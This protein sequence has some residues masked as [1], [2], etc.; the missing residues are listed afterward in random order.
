MSVSWQNLRPLNNSQNTAFEELCCQLASA[1]QVP[2][3]SKFIR[4]GTPDAGVECY[5]KLPSGD[6]WAWQA[7]F[8][9]S[10]PENN[11]WAQIDE[12]LKTAL[13]K[14]PRLTSYTV[15]LPIDRSDPRHQEQIWF[16]DRWNS[17]VEKWRIWAEDK[18]MAVEFNY[19]GESELLLRLSREEHRGRYYFWFNRER[20]S[21]LWFEQHV[22]T[23]IQNAGP[24]Y[25]PELNVDLPIAKIFDGLGRTKAFFDRLQEL[26]GKIKRAHSKSVSVDA[27]AVAQAKY[28]A[29][30]DNV[31]QLLQI[32]SEVDA[33]NIEPLNF[34]LIAEL[35]SQLRNR[36]WETSEAL[37]E[38][39]REVVQVDSDEKQPERQ[40]DVRRDFGYR[41]H[42]LQ[43]L[44]NHAAEL[45]D[46]ARSKEGSLANTPALLLKGNA[47][48]GKSHLL[49]DV[50]R[51]RVK[52]GIPT[53]L[54][55]G[56]QFND[57]E[58]WSQILSILGLTCSREELLGALE[59]A[60]QAR[61]S[62]ALIIIDA[63]N[64]GEGKRL[65][66]KYIA[67][68]LT[69]VLHYP[70]LG[71]ALSVRSSYKN[72]VIPEG[73]IPERL[74]SAEHSGFSEHEY[75]ATSAFFIHYG[76]KAPSVPLL[77]P[78]F[79]NPLFLK[80]FC[81]GLVN[82]GLTEVPPGL[83]GIT[84]I[85][86]FFI[87]SVNKRLSDAELLD[88]DERSKLI[89]KVVDAITLQM[90]QA[91][92][93]W[94]N[95]EEAQKLVNSY[96]PREGYE[97]SLFRH[98][99][100]EGLLAEDMFL[101]EGEGWRLEEGV[102]FSYERL[103]DHLVVK[104]ILENYLNPEKPEEAFASEA[105]LG[106][107]LKDESEVWQN[108]GLIEAL[109]IQLPERIGRELPE[110]VPA[111]ADT[112]PVL[113]AFIESIKWRKQGAINDATYDYINNHVLR[114]RH[115][116]YMIW[117]TLLAVASNKEH[118]LNADYLHGHLMRFEMAERDAWWSVFLH[119]QYRY[120][121]GNSINRLINW[122]WSPNDKSHIDDE[123]IWLSATALSWLLT[124]SNRY[125]R[126]RATKALVSLL[127]PRINVLRIL[128]DRFLDVND[129]YVLERIFSVAYGCAMRSDDHDSVALLASDVYQW[130]FE[131]GEP[132]L[133]ITL[134]DYARGVIE[135]AIH[136]GS[137]LDI[138]VTKIRPPYKSDWPTDIPSKEDVESNKE[139]RDTSIY[140]SV[141][142]WGDFSRYVIGTNTPMFEWTSRRLGEPP[143]PKEQYDAFVASLTKTQLK[144]F[145]LLIRVRNNI[146]YYRKLDGA[147][148]KEIWGF[149]VS[150]EQLDLIANSYEERTRKTLGKKKGEIFD[151]VVVAYLKKPDKSEDK[152]EFDLSI[153]QRWILKQVFDLGW[154]KERFDKF[155]SEVTQYEYHGRS[156]RKPER[157]GKKY[158]W[159]A[160]HEVLAR[161]SDNFIYKGDRWD[162]HLE[163]YQGPWQVFTRDID[164]SCLIKSTASGIWNNHNHTWWFPVI[165][166]H[167]EEIIDAKEWIERTDDLP[168]VQPLINVVNPAD[169]SEW[170]SL[171]AR[172]EWKPPVPIG[173]E[174]EGN[175]SRTLWYILRSSLVRKEDMEEI[176]DWAQQ[177]YCVGNF[178][179]ES[180]SIYRVFLGEFHWGP[181]YLFH[182][183]PYYNHPGWSRV[184][185]ENMT[186]EFH[187]TTETYLKE[188]PKYDCSIDDGYKIEVP[189]KL[190]AD[191]M[192]LNWRSI[193]GNYY[194]QRGALIAFDPSVRHDGPH[195]LLIRKKEFLNFL[196]VNGYDILWTV[197]GEKYQYT[198]SP[199]SEGWYGRLEI[200]GAYRMMAGQLAGALR[201]R[202]D[203]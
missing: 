107:L 4:K 174:R 1:E 197:Y 87:A 61:G 8:F 154:T 194:D 191:G 164:P 58:P 162:G 30:N 124:T 71:I 44:A 93:T 142:G 170:L 9:L 182:N 2:Q 7:K 117:D 172:Y 40:K 151:C 135:K 27:E 173:E 193:E 17:Q 13:E 120:G 159:I 89:Q 10:R 109:C 60:A 14:H 150:D 52:A 36:A 181:A 169:G 16:M 83:Q 59:S 15:C 103:S 37:E 96:L 25:T 130:I 77:N 39:K 12:S 54:I 192:D 99:L 108:R 152:H 20:F 62:K 33:Q 94:L 101:S 31:A 78:E 148:R 156:E 116:N 35:A 177:R 28:A 74:I 19:W 111:V 68:M 18:G 136:N 29:L 11:Q 125:L 50:A 72:T 123:S 73:L 98:M 179:P 132:P 45:S 24:R 64:E 22:E 57:D 82:R 186:S 21:Q 5:W 184:N 196:K 79:Q 158:Q 69:Q 134:R 178:M 92:K 190:I 166:N 97:N 34:D 113:E 188:S 129:P 84:A 3:G 163:L 6:E 26:R 176:Y 46:F 51:E 160:Y 75:E 81:K 67:G 128:I 161:V 122:A 114:F 118:P 195:A 127:T 200:D 155:D 119:K 106:S 189:T 85:F 126:D 187:A 199:G 175:L 141:M 56:E 115:F 47:G 171:D 201:S 131:D 63:L 147:E 165:Y 70:W 102:R 23:S 105:T 112:N 143:T 104:Y 121:E 66:R 146:D 145:E 49:C 80:L 140:H 183:V 38:A 180:Q 139:W 86:D 138:D 76:I 41:R 48:T 185:D 32:L 167:W 100:S 149:D 91:G 95:R 55:L 157:I 88:F 137:E 168:N 203:D 202:F 53:I 43:E 110:F 65:W 144:A 133:H 42:H 198:G 153:I 90:A